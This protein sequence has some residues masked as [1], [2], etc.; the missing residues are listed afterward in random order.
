MFYIY[1]YIYAFFFFKQVYCQCY[2]QASSSQKHM[3]KKQK[4]N[5][6]KEDLLVNR[7]ANAWKS[8]NIVEVEEPLATLHS[9]VYTCD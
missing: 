7:T 1:I 8:Y 2:E 9:D 3:N 5:A 6:K 4:K